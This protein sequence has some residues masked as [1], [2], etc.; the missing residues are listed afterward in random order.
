MFSEKNI[1]TN[2]FEILLDTL[3]SVHDTLV[4]SGSL[5]SPAL[6]EVFCKLLH[7]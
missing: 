4:E 7:K 6:K 3:Q 5:E 2:V 1:L